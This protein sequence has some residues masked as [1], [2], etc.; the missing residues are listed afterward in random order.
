[1]EIWFLYKNVFFLIFRNDV[2]KYVFIEEGDDFDKKNVF[3]CSCYDGVRGKHCIHR[4]AL[5]MYYGVR[6]KPSEEQKLTSRR[7][8]G[9]AAKNNKINVFWFMCKIL[10]QWILMN[11]IIWNMQI[12]IF[13][14]YAPKWFFAILI[15]SWFLYT[16][17]LCFLHLLL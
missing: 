8:R 14:K 7:K 15:I 3:I 9:R 16:F 4:L 5:E 12:W 1:M 6:E 11:K 10:N 13:F 2:T 17:F